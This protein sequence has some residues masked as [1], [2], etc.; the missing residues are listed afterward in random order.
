MNS[1]AEPLFRL[2]AL[3]PP[4]QCPAGMDGDPHV[5]EDEAPLRQSGA[6]KSLVAT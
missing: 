3:L 6:T 2:V 4:L 1:R 5:V